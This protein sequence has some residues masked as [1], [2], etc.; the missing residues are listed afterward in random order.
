MLML[1]QSSSLG[2]PQAPRSPV[3]PLEDIMVE[4]KPAEVQITVEKKDIEE[5][6][7]SDSPGRRPLLGGL[8]GNKPLD[9]DIVIP[10]IIVNN[11][12]Y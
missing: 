10:S 9:V 12:D 3:Q 8:I 2:L 6:G 11:L 7:G 4:Q 1:I 5:S